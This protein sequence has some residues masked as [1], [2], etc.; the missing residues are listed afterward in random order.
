MR[1]STFL[2]RR[3][4]HFSNIAMLHVGAMLTWLVQRP[5]SPS[6]QYKGA[7]MARL[8]TGF[9]ATTQQQFSPKLCPWIKRRMKPPRRCKHTEHMSLPQPS[10]AFSQPARWLGVSGAGSSSSGSLSE[11][12]NGFVTTRQEAVGCRRVSSLH[13]IES[14]QGKNTFPFPY[15]T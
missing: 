1:C 13:V 9:I 6:H 11:I 12:G 8:Q 5:G 14:G 3:C 4:G 15:I 7:C 2:W 10:I